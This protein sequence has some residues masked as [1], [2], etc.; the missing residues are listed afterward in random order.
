[1]KYTDPSAVISPK[2]SVSSVRVIEDKKEGSF[3]IT[4]LNYEGRE[5]LAC[6][7]NGGENEPAG[8]PNSRGIPTWFIIPDEMQEDIMKGVIER[9]KSERSKI[10]DELELIKKEFP[11]VKF[12]GTV[13]NI[14]LIANDLTLVDANLLI[15]IIKR[16]E[17]LKSRNVDIFDMDSE[18]YRTNNPISKIA[19]K[20]HIKLFREAK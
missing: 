6:R 13:M 8:H 16:D 18:G 2:S 12:E 15:E 1:M 9:A 7:W 5:T 11:D 14:Y 3:A 17:V 10:F 20:L 4:K 19:G